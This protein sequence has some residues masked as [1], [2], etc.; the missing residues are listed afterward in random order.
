M[1]LQTDT[2]ASARTFTPA[3]QVMQMKLV[4]GLRRPV[5]VFASPPFTFG[6]LKCK[7][8]AQGVCKKNYNSQ[9]CPEGLENLYGIQVLLGPT[10]GLF[11]QTP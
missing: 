11:G 5:F 6:N 10:Q 4:L 3:M 1:Q 9:S 7:H 2:G 8:K